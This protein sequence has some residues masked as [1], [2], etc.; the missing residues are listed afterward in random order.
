MTDNMIA[1]KLNGLKMIVFDFDGVFTDNKVYLSEE[2]IESVRCDRSDG[3]GIEM[4]RKSSDIA[5]VVLSK[6][7]N[8]VVQKRCDKLKLECYHSVEDK[9]TALK[10]LVEKKSIDIEQVAYVGNDLNDVECMQMVGFAV[11]PKDAYSCAAEVAD[12]ILSRNGG[13]GAVRELCD[14]ILDER[15]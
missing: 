5:L 15:M 13:D 3:M 9:P 4:L 6:E 14:L 12:L 10:K 1:N 2:G 7:K 11:C 8:M